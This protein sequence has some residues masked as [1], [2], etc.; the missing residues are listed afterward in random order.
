MHRVNGEKACGKKSGAAASR[1]GRDGQVEYDGGDAVQ[2]D[3]RYV[4][5][6]GIEAGEA[7]V[8][9]I[10]DPSQGPVGGLVYAGEEIGRCP[11]KVPDGGIVAN[12][13]KVIEYELIVEGVEIDCGTQKCQAQQ[14]DYRATVCCGRSRPAPGGGWAFFF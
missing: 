7:V 3:I 9:G 10:T 6:N 11:G 8:Y 14:G 5:G 4:V 13:G 2:D 12:E 1:Q